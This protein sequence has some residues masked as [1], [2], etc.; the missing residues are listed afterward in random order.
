MRVSIGGIGDRGGV[1][2]CISLCPYRRVLVSMATRGCAMSQDGS[3]S[4]HF[5]KYRLT[6]RT[7]T[8][9]CVRQNT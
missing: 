8:C 5:R 1:E 6:S 2:G 7:P 3:G 9:V 4:F